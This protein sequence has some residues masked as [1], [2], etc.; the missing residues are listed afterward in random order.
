M[1]AGEASSARPYRLPLWLRRTRVGRFRCWYCDRI[2]KRRFKPLTKPDA[3][4]EQIWADADTGRKVTVYATWYC[5]RCA[6]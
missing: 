6:R 2:F 4:G 1:S 5:P 3:N